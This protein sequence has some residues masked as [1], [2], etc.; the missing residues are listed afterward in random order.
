[1]QTGHVSFCAHHTIQLGRLAGVQEDWQAGRANGR[2]NQCLAL[3]IELILKT[4]NTWCCC[5]QV[6][7]ISSPR[8]ASDNGPTSIS[9]FKFCLQRFSFSQQL[10]FLQTSLPLVDPHAS[11][12]PSIHPPA[13]CLPTPSPC[14]PCPAMPCHYPV[15]AHPSPCHPPLSSL[16]IYPASQ[17]FPPS[18]WPGDRPSRPA[19]QASD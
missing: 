14:L 17:P 2:A 13:Y 16:L 3:R 4:K 19:R 12:V 10:A 6:F 15:P 1:M 8:N 18:V 7:F 11:P 5:E 9:H